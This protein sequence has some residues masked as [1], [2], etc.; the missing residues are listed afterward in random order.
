MKTHSTP[1]SLS[2]AALAA[3]LSGCGGAGTTTSSGLVPARDRT[4]VR[5]IARNRGPSWMSPDA[6][7]QSLLYASDADSGVVDV[8]TNYRS[9]RVK[10]VGQLTGFQAPY[11]ECADRAGNVYVVDWSAENVAEYAHAGTARV[12]TISITGAPVGCSVDRRTG[13]LAIAVVYYANPQTHQGGVFVFKRAR[14]TPILY[15][16]P[17]LFHY[18]PAGYDP[19][20]NLFVEADYPVPPKLD[21]LPY[22]G[23]VLK[24]I[25]LDATIDTSSSVMW[26]GTYLAVADQQF[27]G[28]NTLGIYRVSISGFTGK[29]ISSTD[30][31]DTCYLRSTYV[32]QPWIDG[33]ALF[34]GNNFCKSRYGFWSYARGGKPQRLFPTSIAPLAGYGQTV[35]AP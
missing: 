4:V 20:G 14:G 27:Q 26:D 2:V 12:R 22:H 13:N 7:R 33:S 28:S 3:V 29:V 30:Y 32:V 23:H 18:W 16:D 9:S 11:G 1:Y 5:D 35:S 15:Q 31:S 34:G 8:Y 19:H 17:N 25:T 10:L 21:E 24:E 6:A